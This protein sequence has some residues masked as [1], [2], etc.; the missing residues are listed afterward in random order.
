MSDIVIKVA[1]AIDAAPAEVYALLSDYKVGHPSI[2]PEQY[3]KDLIV[4]KGGQGAGTVIRFT[5]IVMGKAYHYHQAVTEPEPGRILQ[6]NDLDQ[7]LTTSF[8]FDPLDDGRQT[9]LTITTTMQASKGVKGFLEKMLNPLALRPI[10][11]KELKQI[12]ARF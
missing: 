7:P 2:V 8:T 6:E 4:E 11:K 3:F 9:H 12:A 10:Y 5:A 1:A